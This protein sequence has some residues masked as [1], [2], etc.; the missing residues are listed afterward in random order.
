MFA[1][2]SAIRP[3]IAATAAGRSGIPSTVTWLRPSGRCRLSPVPRSTSTC[4]SRS[5]ATRS[6]AARNAFQSRGRVTSTPSTSRRRST[7]CSMSSTVTPK[8]ASVE[9]IDEVTPGR[10]LPVSVISRVR[11]GSSMSR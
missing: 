7:I 2:V 1:P 4:I 11:E 10:S 5:A 6:T 9:K 8:A 3:A